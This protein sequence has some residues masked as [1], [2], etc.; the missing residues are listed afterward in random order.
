MSRLKRRTPKD[1]DQKQTDKIYRLLLDLQEKH[2]RFEPSLW[3]GALFSAIVSMYIN[4]GATPDEFE[5]SIREIT[6]HYKEKWMKKR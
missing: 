4:S 5:R 3:C 6:N 2:P 1:D